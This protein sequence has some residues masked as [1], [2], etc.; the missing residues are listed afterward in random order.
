VR[1]LVP[2]GPWACDKA[3]SGARRTPP[4]D[5]KRP[6]LIDSARQVGTADG[7]GGAAFDIP[8]MLFPI[9]PLPM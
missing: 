7:C 5:R 8:P 4:F 9:D 3:M 1:Q 2:G 6:Y